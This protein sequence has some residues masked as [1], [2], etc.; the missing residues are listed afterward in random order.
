MPSTPGYV[1]LS[2]S[3]WSIHNNF[4]FYLNVLAQHLPFLDADALMVK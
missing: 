3:G 1:F 4:L 2:A